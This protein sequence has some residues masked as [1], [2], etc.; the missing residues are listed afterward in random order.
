MHFCL[1][2]LNEFEFNGFKRQ[3]DKKKKTDREI[4]DGQLREIIEG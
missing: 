3:T 2:I 4:K 1:F